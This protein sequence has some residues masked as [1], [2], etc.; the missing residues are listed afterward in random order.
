MAL[1]RVKVRFK[2]WLELDDQPLLGEGGYELLK[3]ID[4]EG[5]IMGACRVLG[6]SYR[7][8]LNYVR[9]VEK[10]VGK[11]VLLTRRGGPGGGEAVLTEEGRALMRAYEV[12]KEAV[13]EALEKV[14]PEL[15]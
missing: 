8:A 11:K 12:V 1:G 7:K 9:R 5:S 15:P 4:E 6:L 3:A 10:L 14:R 2:V 13:E